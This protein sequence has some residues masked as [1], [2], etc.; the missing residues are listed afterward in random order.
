MI[1]SALLLL[2]VVV[3]R[4]LLVFERKEIKNFFGV[5]VT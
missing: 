2:R 5:V 1:L 3:V 4:A